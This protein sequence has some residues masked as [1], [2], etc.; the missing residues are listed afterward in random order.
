M[1]QLL[2]TIILTFPGFILAASP[3]NLS[4]ENAFKVA[5]N[6]NYQIQI[7]RN[8]TAVSNN[9][10][11]R[12]NAGLLPNLNAS[13]G[14]NYTDFNGIQ[15][16]VVVGSASTNTSAGLSLSYT[17]FNGLSQIYA[18]RNLK[19]QLNS[20]ELQ[21]RLTI[22][23]TLLGVAQAYFNLITADQN[24]AIAEEQL[25]VSQERLTLSRERMELGSLGRLDYLSAQVDFN[26]D[27][28]AFMNIQQAE[29]EARRNLNI[30][31]GWQ[32]EKEIAVQPDISPFTNYDLADLS[33]KTRLN[34]SVLLL[35]ASSVEQSQLNL[36]SSKTSFLPQLT[37]ST[38]I[39]RDQTALDFGIGLDDPN[40]ALRHN[41]NFSWNLFNGG[42]RKTN[43]QNARIALKNAELNEA[44]ALLNLEKDVVSFHSAYGNSLTTLASEQKTL[45]YAQ[46]NFERARELF[47]LGQITSLQ[48]RE[49][50]L[51]LSRTQIGITQARYAARNYEL[52]LLQLSGQLL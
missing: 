35:S 50:Q 42:K 46:L 2:T 8:L 26:S 11:T 45:E 41:F 39:G 17:L 20:A 24:L 6:N 21:E 19:E 38:S 22:E 33:E 18:Y 13:T 31:L 32:S 30:L 37:Y 34:S 51:N 12:G 9:N 47:R 36:K 27:S 4:L 44:D 25:R 28:I 1:K 3:E 7:A 52:K 49:A 5:L 23:S 29:D 43:V 10:A 15:N 16:G 14:A 48:F 40:K